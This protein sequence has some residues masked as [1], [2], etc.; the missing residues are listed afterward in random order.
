M[1]RIFDR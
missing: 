1:E